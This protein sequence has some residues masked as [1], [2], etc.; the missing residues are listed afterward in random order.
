MSEND[1]AQLRNE[2][3]ERTKNWGEVKDSNGKTI[4]IKMKLSFEGSVNNTVRGIECLKEKVKELDPELDER[5][6]WIDTWGITEAVRFYNEGRLAWLRG[7][8]E[9]VADLFGILV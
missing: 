2:L 4:Q 6:I 5:D 3:V 9:T 7:D 8:F 1:P